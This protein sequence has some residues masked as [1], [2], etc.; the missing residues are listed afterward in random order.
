MTPKNK[1]YKTYDIIRYKNSGIRKKKQDFVAEEPLL[2][3][4]ENIPY[5]TL[6]RT[7]GNETELAAGLSLS[8]GIIKSPKDISA[9]DYLYKNRIFLKLTDNNKKEILKRLEKK[10]FGNQADQEISSKNRIDNLIKNINIEGHKFNITPQQIN[11]TLEKFLNRQKYYAKTR[12]THAVMFFDSNL[13]IISEGED[14][15]RHNA[16]DK[17]IGSLLLKDKTE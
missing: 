10:R 2:I 6:M 3:T 11:I 9:I 12:G 8:D 7:P 13:D 1:T 5:L 17:A 14:V 16:M 4:I 15:G